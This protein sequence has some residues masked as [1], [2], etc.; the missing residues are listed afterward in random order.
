[1]R[2]LTT[3]DLIAYAE[4]IGTKQKD[5]W[6]EDHI[7]TCRRC[8]S[9]AEGWGDLIQL[10][11]SK[12]LVSAPQSAVRNCIAIY[13]MPQRA[14]ILQE[15]FARLVFDSAAQPEMVGIRGVADSQHILLQTDEVEVYLRI[16][17]APRTILGQLV[18]S[19]GDFVIGARMELIHGGAPVD[20]TMT[21]TLG[22][23]RLNTVPEGDLRLQ[24]E[25]P[26]ECRLI[27]DFAVKGSN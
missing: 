1:M 6:I 26:S 18:R 25:I 20:V 3:T 19:D 27:A 23:F 9:E 10:L 5:K 22:E 13:R 24:A 11:Q 7:Q 12:D 8:A 2:H 21:D 15:I 17:C 14:G 4:A 16:S